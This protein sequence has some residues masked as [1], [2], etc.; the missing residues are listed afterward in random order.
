MLLTEQVLNQMRLRVSS[1][2][3]F[4]I[5]KLNLRNHLMNLQTSEE[6]ITA[7]I[8]ASRAGQYF[9]PLLETAKLLKKI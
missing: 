3:P 7:E 4:Q 1:S 9:R 2:I 8:K 5:D 6:L